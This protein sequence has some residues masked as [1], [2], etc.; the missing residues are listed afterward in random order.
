MWKNDKNN[1]NTI[2]LILRHAAD[3]AQNDFYYS[4]CF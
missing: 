3:L 2:I 4:D 1:I